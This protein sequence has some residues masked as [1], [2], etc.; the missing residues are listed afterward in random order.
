MKGFKWL[1]TKFLQ[2]FQ[3]PALLL[4]IHTGRNYK[5]VCA[6]RKALGLR[7]FEALGW[8]EGGWG[9]GKALN[10]LGITNPPWWCRSQ[11][12][13]DTSL[14]FVLFS[15]NSELLCLRGSGRNSEEWVRTCSTD[16]IPCT[17]PWKLLPEP[18]LGPQHPL[19]WARAG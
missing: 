19:G 17:F 12:K 8:N 16:L 14:S 5:Y 1:P 18:A 11:K 2:C 15:N 9:R 3:E 7:I 10:F 6:A 4:L 13:N